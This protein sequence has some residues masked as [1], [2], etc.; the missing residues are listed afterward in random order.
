MPNRDEIAQQALALPP[1][2]RA[3][4]AEL[5]ER[6]LAAGEFATPEIA[7]AWI[8]EAERRA[9]AIDR[10]EMPV[11]DWREVMARLRNRHATAGQRNR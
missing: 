9:E 4:V 10:G 8:A 5:L 1:D 3:Y 7:V 6:S 2:D 11:S